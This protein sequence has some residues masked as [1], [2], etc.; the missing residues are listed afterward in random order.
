[1]LAGRRYRLGLTSEQ[2][3]MAEEFGSICRSVWNTALEQRREYRRRGA[4]MNYVPQAAELADAKREHEWLRAAPS[5]VLQQTL[6]DLDKACRTHG[7]FKV[8]WRSKARWNPSFRFPAGNLITVERM[9]RKWGRAKLPKLGWVAFRWSR[10]PGGEIRS[11]TVSRKTGHWYISFLVEDGVVTPRHHAGTPIGIDRGVVVAV[12]T[13]TGCFHDRGCVTSGEK[14]RYRR[15]QQRLARS[16]KG[17]ANRRRTLVAMNRIVGRI[18]DRRTDFTAWTANRLTTRHSVVVLEDLRTKNMTASAK[19]TQAE[20]GRNVRQKAGLNRAILDKGWHRMERAI[21]NAARS[22]GTEVVLVN[23]AYTSQ[24]C[25][26]CGCVDAKNRKSQAVFVC[27]SCGHRDHADV[28]AAKNILSAAGH[29][30]P[31]CGDLAVGRSVKQEPAAP[32]GV[33]RQLA[34]EPVGISRL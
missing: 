34:F 19:G 9:N 16:E 20:P 3:E 14:A 31:A 30:V 28:N 33:P 22:T 15:L 29:A 18:T 8:R 2:A 7:T 6:K 4:W 12:T 10:P 17:S 26:R 1:M 25:N 32:R 5:H 23:P 27:T 11:A 21:R 24:T 13:S